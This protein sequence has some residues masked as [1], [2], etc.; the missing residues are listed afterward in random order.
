MLA[1]KEP[2][3]QPPPAREGQWAEEKGGDGAGC[4]KHQE[5]CAP[6]QPLGWSREAHPP[7]VRGQELASTTLYN[8]L[9]TEVFH[10]T[11]REERK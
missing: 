1:T 7:L 10:L 9:I 6:Q 2:S 11:E 4:H 5:P 8:P 3:G